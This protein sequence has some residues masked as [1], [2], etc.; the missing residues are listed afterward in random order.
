MLISILRDSVAS[1]DVEYVD[2][3]KKEKDSSIGSSTEN[4]PPDQYLWVRMSLSCYLY[5][6]ISDS[7]AV[8]DIE[9]GAPLRSV[10]ISMK[11]LELSKNHVRLFLSSNSFMLHHNI[12]VCFSLP[13][14]S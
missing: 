5:N 1:M 6:T 11:F 12:L 3:K 13:G 14:L 8:R 2:R 9:N 4:N 7:F 10:C